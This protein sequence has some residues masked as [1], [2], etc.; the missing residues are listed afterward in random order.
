[1]ATKVNATAPAIL[2]RWHAKSAELDARV[3]ALNGRDSGRDR[4]YQRGFRELLDTDA[5]MVD[6]PIKTRADALA[7]TS[8]ALLVYEDL[9]LE[10]NLSTVLHQ[11]RQFIEE[12][13]PSPA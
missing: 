5:D 8:W 9:G 2:D 4:I 1:V 6:A 10:P 12:G 3:K 13:A 7:K 11:L